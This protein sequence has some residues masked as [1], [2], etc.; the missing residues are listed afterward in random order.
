M[1]GIS[2]LYNIIY[3]ILS[4]ISPIL[5]PQPG[6]YTFSQFVDVCIITIES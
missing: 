2:Y 5:Y 6:M 1:N 3:I 4:L